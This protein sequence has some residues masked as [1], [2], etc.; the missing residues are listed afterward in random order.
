[1]YTL[2]GFL[3]LQDKNPYIPPR[4]LRQLVLWPFGDVCYLWNGRYS[5]CSLGRPFTCTVLPPCLPLR[6]GSSSLFFVCQLGC[7]FSIFPCLPLSGRSPASAL[8]SNCAFACHC[9]P[10]TASGY[11]RWLPPLE[12]EATRVG[13]TTTGHVH[14]PLLC[15]QYKLGNEAALP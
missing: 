5:L 4:F 7:H 6:L 9:N 14:C 12:P 13:S 10:H 2:T 1:M 8:H 11:A 3:L 15:A